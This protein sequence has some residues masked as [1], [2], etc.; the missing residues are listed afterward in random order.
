MPKF[1]KNIFIYN[2]ANR[3]R[4]PYFISTETLNRFFKIAGD[5][6]SHVSEED[7]LA[8]PTKDY[9]NTAMLLMI[10]N[11]CYDI[12]KC[13]TIDKKN[14]VWISNTIIS[15]VEDYS[16]QVSSIKI[17]E[18]KLYID[19]FF[20]DI[21]GEDFKIYYTNDKESHEIKINKTSNNFLQR[22]FF[23]KIVGQAYLLNAVIDLDKANNYNIMM[24]IKDREI[25]ICLK[26]AYN[27][28]NFLYENNVI[29]NDKKTEIFI[30]NSS[31]KIR[32]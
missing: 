19:G 8:Y 28:E 11:N 7:I 12:K 17:E 10:K 18:N 9:F 21:I 25:P 13:V 26:N 15:N 16:F 5:M 6:L 22:R 3:I 4:M 14:N 30:D 32:I 1:I 24:K 27:E 29:I 31:I 2:V 23:D 20:N